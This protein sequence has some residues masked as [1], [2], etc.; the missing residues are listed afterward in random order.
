MEKIVIVNL[1]DEI[2]KE[3]FSN[4]SQECNFRIKNLC[5]GVPNVLS[6]F[7][8]EEHIETLS[9]H[10]YVK[11][12]DYDIP[13]PVSTNLP[14]YETL[15]R[16][17]TTSLPS[18]IYNGN[19]YGAMMHY[20]D[21]DVLEKSSTTYGNKDTANTLPNSLYYQR[22]FGEHI[23]IVTMEVGPIN[24][25]LAGVH[26]THDD[27]SFSFTSNDNATSRITAMDWPNLEI[28]DNNQVTADSCLSSHGMGV[29][30]A[31][32]GIS[33]GFAKKANL[34]ATYAANY[35]LDGG[36]ADD[37]P[38]IMSTIINWHNSKSNNPITG[39]PNPTILIHEY[40]W[41]V[42]R[43]RAIPITDIASITDLN[44]TISEPPGGWGTDFRPFVDRNIIPWK[45]RDPDTLDWYWCAV[46]PYQYEY[47]S[48]KTSI[49]SCWDNGIINVVAA[50]NNG[51]VY[52]KN[53]DA[54][55]TG[56]YCTTKNNYTYYLI[57][58]NSTT[59]RAIVGQAVAVASV[60]TWYPFNTY[61]PHGRSKAIDVAAGMNSESNAYLDPYS[62]RGEGIDIVG[63]GANHY[64]GYPSSTMADGD[65]YGLFSGTSNAAPT[66]AG[67]VACLL[68]QYFH[69]TGT[70]PTPDTAKTLLIAQGRDIVKDA[71]STT[72][73]DV[74]TPD[75]NY[76]IGFFTSSYY[77]NHIEDN[78]SYPNGTFRLAERAGTTG[79]RAFLNGHGHVR[80]NTYKNR[81]S[82]KALKYPRVK[83]CR[84]P[85]MIMPI[86]TVN[87]QQSPFVF[88]GDTIS[89]LVTSEHTRPNETLYWTTSSPADFT[90]SS[91]SVV[92]SENRSA[93]FNVT[94]LDDGITEGLEEVY[95]YLHTESDT[96]PIV[97]VS[98]PI[99]IQISSGVD[100]PTYVVAPV[101]NNVNEGS[102]L[103]FLVT[104]TNVANGTTLY[105]T[106][107]NAGDFGTSSGSF[108]V[109]SNA[110]SFSV[111]PTADTTT[112]GAETFQAQI[113]TDSTSGTIVATSSNVTINDTSQTPAFNPDYTITVTNSGN[114]YLFTGSDR[115]GSYSN[116][117]QPALSFNSGDKVRFSVSA[118]SHPFFLIVNSTG[119]TGL[120]NQVSGATGQ[121][122]SMGDVDWTTA[123]DGTGTY[124][125]T[126]SIHSSMKNSITI[127]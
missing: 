94:I 90:V 114:N 33:G 109:N 12:L 1:I 71:Y 18:T 115:S 22:F 104:S 40:Q 28:P 125:Y 55:S 80:S 69:E 105:W 44:G 48:L 67:K 36:D 102:S 91:G 45:V 118:A 72:W 106:I 37:Y 13:T 25:S 108:T 95:I 62:N 112:E 100:E 52:V 78:V 53:D 7:I 101:A 23:D 75:T 3:T 21:S 24:S 81:T 84:T 88:E 74:P 5:T 86:Y 57:T 89:F 66:V 32:G 120:E 116:T 63:L 41:L 11:K 31:S 47:T 51:G 54:K 34:Y 59:D 43:R 35:T 83:T 98:V 42:D 6:I 58:K 103:T 127:S 96:G 73:A 122:A 30:S 26:K 70:Y 123:T 61:G 9:S 4:L 107:T 8:N 16:T 121:G 119:G 93:T 19:D 14:A 68:E 126:C 77:N 10:E 111:T 2:D 27:F 92:L 49:D 87:P 85:K 38:E 64:C 29:L 20:L 124:Y 17:W 79:I 110:G 15:D 82:G 60:D 76:Q 50:G 56:V 113:R 39:V 46:F 99:T 117:S 65:K 97:A